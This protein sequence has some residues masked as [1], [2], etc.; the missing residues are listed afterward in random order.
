[1]QALV[2]EVGA[3]G[4]DLD[5]GVVEI[6]YRPS[7]RSP[8]TRANKTLLGQDRPHELRVKVFRRSGK[9]AGVIG[10]NFYPIERV[11]ESRCYK[12]ESSKNFR[13]NN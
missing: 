5:A 8:S 10:V 2:I 4:C 6:E 13:V 3:P 1:M 12:E 9:V 11:A 7:L